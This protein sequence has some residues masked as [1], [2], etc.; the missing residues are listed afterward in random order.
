MTDSLAS[1]PQWFSM[2]PKWLQFAAKHLLEKGGFSTEDISEF[3]SLCLR[4]AEGKLVDTDYSFS[5]TTFSP[6][7]TT[8]L[9]LYSISDVRGVNALAPTKPLEFGQ[10]NISAVYGYN[11]SG[12]SG[13]V[14]LLKHVCGSRHHGI[15]HPNVYTNSPNEQNATMKFKKNGDRLELQLDGT[16]CLR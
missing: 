5:A 16:R 8:D 11:G 12:K 9:R 2:R 4:E 3:A 7:V 10:G 13:Y 14:R 15:L 1:L 6:N